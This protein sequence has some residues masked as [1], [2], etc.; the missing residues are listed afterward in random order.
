MIEL[1]DEDG[2]NRAVRYFLMLYGN[3]S[4]TVRDM[5]NHLYAVGYPFWPA[6]VE[7]PD[8]QGHLTKG[9]A[10]DWLRHLFSL[11]PRSRYY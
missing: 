10:Q 1:M 7:E 5:M 8:A 3:S 2:E 4:V 6:W 9:G 11:E